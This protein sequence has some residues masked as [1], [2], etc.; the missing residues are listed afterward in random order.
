[1]IIENSQKTLESEHFT[2]IDQETLI[3]LLSLDRLS[4]DEIDLLV[5]VS[6]WIDC[7]VQRQGLPVNGENRRQVF[8]PI[9]SYI[10]FT[11]LTPENIANYEE[12]DELLTFEERGSLVLHLLNKRN[13][14]VIELKTPR[15]TSVCSVFVVDALYVGDLDYSETT[16]LLVNR[17]VS[18]RKIYTTHSGSAQHLCLQIQDSNREDLTSNIEKSVQDGRLC[19]SFNPPFDL[20]PNTNYT[21]QVDGGGKMRREDRLSQQLHLNYK[22]S[23]SFYLA[24][25]DNH[26]CIGGLEFSLH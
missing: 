8:Q 16:G 20:E 12:I 24:P 19:F 11:A 1:M 17:R 4:V 7:E 5:A 14:L 22:E 25:L 18:I 21:L 3:S 23:V 13:P 15:R 10:L 26:H 2:Q 6:K 9:K